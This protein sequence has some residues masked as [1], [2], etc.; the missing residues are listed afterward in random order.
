M[1]GMLLVTLELIL[2]RPMEVLDPKGSRQLMK[3]HE[4]FS[5][6]FSQLNA[7][8]SHATF[9]SFPAQFEE[10][11]FFLISCSYVPFIL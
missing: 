10:N 9:E 6:Q 11:S 5:A 4:A 3:G 7:S 8:C 2:C 1:F